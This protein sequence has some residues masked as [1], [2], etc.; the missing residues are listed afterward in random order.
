[1]VASA[2]QQLALV[3]D[4]LDFSR[5][6]LNTLN[7]RPCDVPLAPLFAEMEFVLASMV[8][9]KPVR[10]IVHPVAAGLGV[11]ADRERLRQILTNLLGNA[12]KFTAAGAIELHAQANDAVVRIGVRDTGPGIAAEHLEA[13]FEPFRQV[14]SALS[15]L[16][17]G[18][19]L[20]ISRQ[21]STLMGGALAVESTA[22]RGST[23]WVTLP[24]ARAADV[25]VASGADAA[26][27]RPAADRSRAARPR[28]DVS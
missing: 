5:I 23:F 11:H 4:L 9:H 16:G 10:A 12:A 21:L 26:A 1:M 28:P 18:L 8:R 13:I 19:G 20:A 17:A 25:T 7:V 2:R 24:A 14:D 27:P 22:G 15:G 3:E 6:E